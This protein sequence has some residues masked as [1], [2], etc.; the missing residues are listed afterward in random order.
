LKEK[1]TRDKVTRRTRSSGMIEQGERLS[2]EA[3][4]EDK[5]R[6]R[7]RGESIIYVASHEREMKD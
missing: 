2:T 7:K 6:K 4:S 3:S 5:E 1:E